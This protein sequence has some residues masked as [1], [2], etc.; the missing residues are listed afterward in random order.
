MQTCT[1]WIHIQQQQSGISAVREP[2][3][4]GKN[5]VIT[6]I[7][8]KW[9]RVLRAEDVSRAGKRMRNGTQHC[10]I[11]ESRREQILAPKWYNTKCITYHGLVERLWARLVFFDGTRFVLFA[12]E[13]RCRVHRVRAPRTAHFPF[14]NPNSKVAFSRFLLLSFHSP[15]LVAALSVYLAVSRGPADA[16]LCICIFC[17]KDLLHSS[18]K[19][20]A[21]RNLTRASFVFACCIHRKRRTRTS[22]HSNW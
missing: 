15:H 16:R 17:E 18:V 4:S 7:P 22:T 19:T 21:T 14:W 10:I 13:A 9:N 2:K 1:V 20:N 8:L 12:G 5:N 3:A 6:I 11:G